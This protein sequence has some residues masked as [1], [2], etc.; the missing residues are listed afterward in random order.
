MWSYVD[1]KK[2]GRIFP[3]ERIFSESRLDNVFLGTDFASCSICISCPDHCCDGGAT[4]FSIIL[5]QDGMIIVG[6]IMIYAVA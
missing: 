5:T 6:V 3:F 4:S 1:L 2:R